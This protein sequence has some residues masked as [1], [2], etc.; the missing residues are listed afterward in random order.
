MCLEVNVWSE[1]LAY[2]FFYQWYSHDI[3]TILKWG[4]LAVRSYFSGVFHMKSRA[5]TK[6]GLARL[7]SEPMGDGY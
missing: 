5:I 7:A 2:R 4:L 1:P 3:K 6:W